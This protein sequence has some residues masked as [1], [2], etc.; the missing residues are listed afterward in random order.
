MVA[1]L[2]LGRSH[3]LL[4]SISLNTKHILMQAGLP[5][6]SPHSCSRLEANGW[7]QSSQ[8]Y[9]LSGAIQ[10][11]EKYRRTQ[12]PASWKYWGFIVLTKEVSSFLW[13]NENTMRVS[14]ERHIIKL[15]TKQTKQYSGRFL[16]ILL[17][18]SLN[19][20]EGGDN[21]I[22]KGIHGLMVDPLSPSPLSLSCSKLHC[23]MHCI[24]HAA[25]ISLP[26]NTHE[27]DQE[28]G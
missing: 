5:P 19:I 7:I 8:L 24:M 13:L 3:F 18:F 16:T 17:L 28:N 15:K 12:T 11:R 27:G 4:L 14:A 9:V 21:V 20:W 23:I 10:I 22:G 25:T 1:R 2:E 26:W 6:P